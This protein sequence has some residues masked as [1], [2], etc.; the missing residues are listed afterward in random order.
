M[1]MAKKGHVLVVEDNLIN[2]QVVCSF[3]ENLGYTFDVANDGLAAVEFARKVSYLVILMDC[4]LPEMDGFEATTV[5]RKESGPN[6]AVPIIAVTANAV[7][8]G[9]ERCRAVG[10]DDVICKPIN[11]TLLSSVMQQWITAGGRVA[12]AHGVPEP[13][14]INP[15]ALRQWAD[16]KTIGNVDAGSKLIRIFLSSSARLMQNIRDGLV[17]GD[18]NGTTS[19]AHT[20]KSAAAH[21]GADAVADLCVKLERCNSAQELSCAKGLLADLE[22]HYT[23]VCQE[24]ERL[25]REKAV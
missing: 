3:L 9:A 8:D 13:Q 25:L 17:H 16:L 6:Q 11:S 15:K 14:I 5:I 19:A 7:G 24:L 1:G 10:M 21:V 20:L 23:Q 2:Q 4:Q 18:L 22:N 12:G